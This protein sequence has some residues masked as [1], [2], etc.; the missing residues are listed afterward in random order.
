MFNRDLTTSGLE[1]YTLRSD[2][3]KEGPALTRENGICA[4][5]CAGMS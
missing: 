1:V 3:T 5:T 4:S 2:L